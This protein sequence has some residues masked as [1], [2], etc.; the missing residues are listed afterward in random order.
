MRLGT[1]VK[2]NYGSWGRGWEE[3]RGEGLMQLIDQVEIKHV[4]L[5]YKVSQV[6]IRMSRYM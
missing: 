1:P 5:S 2:K 4:H 3:H 6:Y